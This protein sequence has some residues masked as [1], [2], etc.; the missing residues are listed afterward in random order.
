MGF[1]VQQL[2]KAFQLLRI[3][4]G[5]IS[6]EITD[7]RTSSPQHVISTLL[8]AHL[9]LRK[10]SIESIFKTRDVTTISYHVLVLRSY[11]LYI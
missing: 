3:V 10:A 2:E 7:N 9:C 6:G 11:N 1:I 4:P 8:H 5:V